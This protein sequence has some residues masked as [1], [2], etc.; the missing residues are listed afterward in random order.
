MSWN[1]Q[2]RLQYWDAMGVQTIINIMKQNYIGMV[3]D[4]T[5]TDAPL[6]ISYPDPG[7]VFPPIRGSEARISFY[8]TNPYTFV[9]L[10][11]SGFGAYRV[12]VVKGGQ[13]YWNGY[14]YPSVYQ[15][16]LGSAPHVVEVT[17]S[18]GLG[19]IKNN[20]FSDASLNPVFGRISLLTALRYSLIKTGLEAK[21]A[22]AVHIS[23]NQ[24]STGFLPNTLIDTRA[25]IKDG[26]WMSCYDV[27]TKIL[28]ALNARIY[29]YGGYFHV[30][31]FDQY[32]TQFTMNYYD[33]SGAYTGSGNS[34]IYPLTGANVENVRR[35]MSDAMLSISPPVKQITIKNTLSERESFNKGTFEAIYWIS[36]TKPA[37]W[38][39]YGTSVNKH[40]DNESIK[41]NGSFD[42]GLPG[43]A[44]VIMQEIDITNYS[45]S[46]R[47]KFSLEAYVYGLLSSPQINVGLWY[48]NGLIGKQM[49]SDGTW[50]GSGN[51]A[52]NMENA[53]WVTYEITSNVL[54]LTPISGR[55][56]Y[57]R[58]YLS[59]PFSSS[60][61]NVN[62]YVLIKNL[63]LE[64]VVHTKTVGIITEN[65]I[66]LKNEDEVEIE[67]NIGLNDDRPEIRDKAPGILMG[68]N[69]QPL[70]T[71]TARGTSYSDTSLM[72]AADYTHFYSNILER[73]EGTIYGHLLMNFSIK[74]VNHN[75]KCYYFHA[76]TTNDR[77]CLNDVVMIECESDAGDGTITN[78]SVGYTLPIT[79]GG[80]PISTELGQTLPFLLS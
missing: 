72:L 58:I 38:T 36:D 61:G 68:V 24:S 40:E 75:N 28:T 55:Q 35:L 30:I 14:I 63:K 18:D 10:F 22:E 42:S 80:A 60:G 33:Q 37:F 31:R 2:Y 65:I 64:N 13:N 43:S 17:A 25:F 53:K 8:S 48:S 26:E 4:I 44:N 62:D 19:Y 34:F 41:I 79:L 71:I 7:E 51:F 49:A 47:L 3:V 78:T 12:E 20:A 11:T 73:I 74:D 6:F 46:I 1:T 16:I 50:T 52:I 66:D 77:E 59:Q 67:I 57:I 54:E 15:Q 69:G 5:G 32:G 45:G 21:I 39:T 9:H 56:S 23:H 29:Q 70:S 27:I 76:I